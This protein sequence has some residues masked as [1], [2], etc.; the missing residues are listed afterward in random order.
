MGTST[1]GSSERWL[2]PMTDNFGHLSIRTTQGSRKRLTYPL[3]SVVVVT[4]LQT[5]LPCAGTLSREISNSCHR[6][7]VAKGPWLRKGSCSLILVLLFSGIQTCLE[8]KSG[9]LPVQYQVTSGSKGL[10]EEVEGKTRDK[11]LIS[12]K[13]Q[14]VRSYKTFESSLFSTTVCY[15]REVCA[16]VELRCLWSLS[17]WPPMG[18]GLTQR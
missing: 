9:S 8:E 5:S 13:R 15:E 3:G 4:S 16:E 7:V 2:P 14:R 10:L 1:S 17:R 18:K 6:S 11:R 12:T